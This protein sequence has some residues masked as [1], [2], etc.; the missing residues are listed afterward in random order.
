MILTDILS[1]ISGIGAAI[2]AFLSWRVS[3]NSAENQR[4]SLNELKRKNLFDL[5]NLHA[6]RANDASQGL[7][8][9]DWNFSQ[10]MNVMRAIASASREVDQLPDIGIITKEEG[11][12][13][14][15][16]RLDSQILNSLSSQE[17][18]DCAYAPVGPVRW[19]SHSKDLWEK[20]RRFL[21]RE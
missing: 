20:N 15:I 18:P 14:F 12:L 1:A 2:A 8:S 10:F 5:L 11:I 4:D 6:D 19:A 9:Q 7:L 13:F 3:V 17:P 21:R 16:D